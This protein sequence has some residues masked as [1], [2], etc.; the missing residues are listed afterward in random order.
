VRILAATALYDVL[1]VAYARTRRPDLRISAQI[2]ATLGA[3]R[4]V[5]NA[6]AGSGSYEDVHT[7]LAVGPGPVMIAQRPPG[8]APAVRAVAERL[9]LADGC[10]DAVAALPTVHHW[11][12]VAARIAELRRIARRRIVV[13]TWDQQ[14]FKERF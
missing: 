3:A 13:S 11:S 9:P 7:V 4:E 6:G 12:D 8:G 14:V 2:H 10:A 5:I 1:G